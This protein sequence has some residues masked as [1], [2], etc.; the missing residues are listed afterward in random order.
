MNDT[1]TIIFMNHSNGASLDIEVP[2]DISAQD[3]FV[4]LNKGLRLG[5]DETNRHNC[6][7]KAEK[8]TAFLSGSASLKQMGVRNGTII[9]FVRGDYNG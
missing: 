5:I 1:A 6:F 9:N 8:P 2:L 4:A 3:L 7:L